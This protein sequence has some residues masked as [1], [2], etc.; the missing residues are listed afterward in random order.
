MPRVK[1]LD[2]KHR[3]RSSFGRREFVVIIISIIITTVGIKATDDL[4]NGKGLEVEQYGVC[5]EGM[6]QVLAPKGDFCIDK[7]ENSA[8]QDCQFSNPA[9]Q[10]ET[11]RNLDASACKAAVAKG[12]VIWRN[13]S[14]NQA[15]IA[16]ARAGKRLPTNQE[17]SL[18]AL[19]TPD[20]NEDWLASDCNV[21][22]NWAGGI[23]LTGSGDNC[24]SSAGAQD[25]TGNVWE[26]VSGTVNDG[27]YE[28]KKLPG[29][30]YVKAVD[31][32][33]MPSAT[34]EAPDHNYYNDYA[35]IKNSGTR[36]IARGGYWANRGEAGQYSAYIVYE[37][38]FAGESIGF[39]C[40]K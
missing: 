13:I 8:S 39:R 31:E 1:V 24:V 3:K 9:T 7:Y 10:E 16:C 2:L 34:S 27:L 26:W 40:V 21:N 30:G 19:G 11:R 35:S 15:S 23:G 18:A 17:W 32:N 5:P 12:A 28:N 6:V 20:K 22:G 33:G 29:Q 38:S 14:Q 37:P 4:R 36:A 25:M